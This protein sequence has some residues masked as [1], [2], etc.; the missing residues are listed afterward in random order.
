[1]LASVLSSTGALVELQ[2][3]CLSGS[4]LALLLDYIYTGALPC[5]YT[6]QQYYNLLTAARHLQMNK[7]QEALC[8]WQETKVNN[9]DKSNKS[10]GNENQAYENI[11]SAHRITADTFNKDS[12]CNID[13]WR[14]GEETDI[15]G[16]QVER[17]KVDTH[18]ETQVHSASIDQCV[19][20]AETNT[21]G[22]KSTPAASCCSGKDAST[23][24]NAN[25]CMS[26]SS[27]N[28]D[29]C[30]QI[31]HLTLQNVIQNTSSTSEGYG[32]S[33]V[34][35]D[36]QKDQFHSA[37]TIKPETWQ[38]TTDEEIAR[39]D[40]GTRSSSSPSSSLPHPCCGAVP[41]IC[42]SSRAAMLQPAQVSTIPTY[43]AVSQA[44]VNSSRACPSR[45]ASTENETIV[46]G[47]TAEHKN[48]YGLENL[49]YTKNKDHTGMERLDSKDSSDQCAS[50]DDCYKSNKGQS[51]TLQH[52]FTCGSTGH[53]VKTDDERMAIKDHN[54][55]NA[56][57]DLFQEKNHKKHLRDDSI[58]FT[59][60]L[61]YKTDLSF[62]DLPTKHQRLDWSVCHN[63]SIS[64]AAE[65]HSDDV[66]LPVE[67]SDVRS[68]SYCEDFCPKRE[69]KEEH[70]YTSKCLAEMDRHH[71]PYNLYGPQADWYPRLH[72][73]E[74]SAQDAATNQ[75]E[76]DP[77]NRDTATEDK[78]HSSGVCLPLSNTPESSLDNVNGGISAFEC[79]TSL[80]VEKISDTETSEQHF[81]FP[82]PADSN[83]SD[84]V[85]SA[86]GHSYHG[87][88]HYHCV[89]QEDTLFSHGDS[90]QKHSHLSYP[91]HSDQS[92]EEEEI[93]A[94]PSR[95]PVRQHFATGTT[96]QFL[97]LDIS[98]KHAELLVCYKDRADREKKGTELDKNTN[99]QMNEAISVAAV[100]KRKITDMTKFGAEC[101]DETRNRSR[102]READVDERK[103]VG[104]EQSRSR[105]E[106]KNNAGVME[107]VSKHEEGE[108]Q[109]STLRVCSAP[110]VPDSAQSSVS[111]TFS[112][113]IP[114]ALPARMSTNISAHLST[115]LHH[116]FQCSLCDRSFSQRGS[117]NRHVR[118]HLGVRPFP[119]PRC[120]MTFSR[121]YRVTEHMRVHQRCTLGNDF[122]HPPASSI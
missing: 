92:S 110:S 113:C 47:I 20:E 10:T 42:H 75:H 112:V 6:Q 3:P 64:A 44:L 57:C 111:S 102:L 39:T 97:L 32:V 15:C 80:D 62:E 16:V 59:G 99:E 7:L 14:N 55:H 86:V 68:N 63:V 19:D 27:G 87:H 45:S 95:S 31:T 43:H 66:P 60:G 67:G 88:V 40:E 76:H 105:A 74:T 8:A 72:I 121:Q 71:S 48:H 94:S 23:L 35:K 2:A 18:A 79:N 37:G 41:V 25:T 122:P 93:F 108:N 50:Q 82:I 61:K 52:K 9:T 91:D 38:N 114:S 36:M 26:E 30:R 51:D 54:D 49:N 103:S 117:L 96:D 84:P 115:P 24:S 34:G 5:T 77:N 100:D 21:C 28:T 119:C 104:R 58:S 116:A 109:T 90:D 22:A 56:H 107:E 69:A 46:E 118:S 81:S 53:F 78:R 106:V 83:M 29:N 11:I 12:T 13:A 1:M 70:G 73:A 98:T 120:P 85:Y 65:E 4:V 101:F 33:R 17:S 89:P